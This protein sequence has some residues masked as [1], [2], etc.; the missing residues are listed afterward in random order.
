MKFT[1]KSEK[2]I[3]TASLFPAGTYEGEIAFAEDAVSTAGND[4]IRLTVMVIDGSGKSRMVKDYLV[5]AISYKLRHIAEACGV[6]DKYEAGNLM[7]DDL[8]GHGVKVRLAIDD[9]NKDFPPKNVIQD[10]LV[11]GGSKSQR[12]KAAEVNA[13]AAKGMDDHIPF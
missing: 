2:E 12:A 10:Y 11:E 8:Q 3:Q 6:L 9:K 1:P 5:E 7:A 4:M 13:D